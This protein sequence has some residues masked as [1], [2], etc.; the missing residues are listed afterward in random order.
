MVLAEAAR[1]LVSCGAEPIAITDCLN[2]GSPEDEQVVS[3]LAEM[4]DGLAQAGLSLQIPVISGNVSLYNE[5]GGK[6]IWPTLTIG[7]VGL[8]ERLEWITSPSFKKDQDLIFLLGKE[9]QGLGGSELQRSILGSLKPPLPDLDLMEERRC[10]RALL[11]MIRKGI[12]KSAHDIGEGGLA[13]ALAESCLFG[14]KGAHIS[15]QPSGKKEEALFSEGGPS[16]LIS[17]NQRDLPLARE[18]ARLNQIPLLPLG[19]VRGERLQILIGD[20]KI[21]DLPL[22]LIKER[23]MKSLPELLEGGL[24]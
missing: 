21:V 15:F 18:I 4:V 5:Q 22:D 24:S 3:Q 20:K 17:L 23:Y 12:I 19:E 7:M 2:L 8:I 11:E 6:A 9:G 10:Q 13:V 1:N 16:F 14:G